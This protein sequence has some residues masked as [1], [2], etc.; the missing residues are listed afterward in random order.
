MDL[1]LLFFAL[2]IA[3]C[4]S[5]C[6]SQSVHANLDPG[7]LILSKQPDSTTQ[8]S[9]TT[10][11]QFVDRTTPEPVDFTPLASYF[12][13]STCLLIPPEPECSTNDKVLLVAREDGKL[14]AADVRNRKTVC[15]IL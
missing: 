15:L 8:S 14:Q 1:I 12:F 6:S 3:N 10:N 9:F 5:K 4:H 11:F 13:S 7:W 2:R